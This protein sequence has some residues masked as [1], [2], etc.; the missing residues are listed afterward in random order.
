VPGGPRRARLRVLDLGGRPLTA[1]KIEVRAAGDRLSG[2]GAPATQTVKTDA[3]GFLEF[4]FPASTH[5]R[6]LSP[7][8]EIHY[9]WPIPDC[10]RSMDVIAASRRRVALMV[11]TRGIAPPRFVAG[12]VLFTRVRSL[13]ADRGIYVTAKSDGGPLIATLTL[14]GAEEPREID[15][16]GGWAEPLDLRPE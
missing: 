6:L 16:S 10:V 2:E 12:E 5:V 1:L 8:V 4:D 3:K 11:T 14:R 7:A 15:L 9:G 13:A